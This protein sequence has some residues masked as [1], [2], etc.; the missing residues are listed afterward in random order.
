VSHECGH[1]GRARREIRALAKQ[2]GD[3]HPGAIRSGV[4]GIALVRKSLDGRAVAQGSLSQRILLRLGVRGASAE[5]ADR[6]H[7]GAAGSAFPLASS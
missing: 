6:T 1:F 5:I 2:L 4:D 3:L 7:G